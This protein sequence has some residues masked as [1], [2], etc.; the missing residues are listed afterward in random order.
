MDADISKLTA[1]EQIDYLLAKLQ[2]T[3]NF[4]SLEFIKGLDNKGGQTD[5]ALWHAMEQSSALYNRRFV[6]VGSYRYALADESRRARRVKT[7][8]KAA[9]RIVQRSLAELRRVDPTSLAESER[10]SLAK[11]EEQLAALAVRTSVAVRKA[12]K[13]KPAGL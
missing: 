12:N 8:T 5:R 9:G 7:R 3:E 1:N 2:D 4:H 13:K 6:P 10:K 11:V